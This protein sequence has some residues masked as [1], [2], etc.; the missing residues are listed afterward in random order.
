ME[1]NKENNIVPKTIIKEIR[2]VITNNKEKDDIQEIKMSKADKINLAN[3]IENEMKLAAKNLDFE[4]A[5]TLR[6]ALYEL[7]AEK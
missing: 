6:D 7:K 5:M 2:E 1:Y 3:K 4:R